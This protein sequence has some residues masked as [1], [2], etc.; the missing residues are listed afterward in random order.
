M[1]LPGESSH[2][3]KAKP[4]RFVPLAPA[5]RRQAT[6]HQPSVLSSTVL[7]MK[8]AYL[9]PKNQVSDYFFRLEWVSSTNDNS[10]NNGVT[11]ILLCK[12]RTCRRGLYVAALFWDWSSPPTTTCYN[13]LCTALVRLVRLPQ[14]KTSAAV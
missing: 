2:Q 13:M 14:S 4:A 11:I 8:S 10:N 7:S 12:A 9:S 6:Y 3:V 1:V 5:A